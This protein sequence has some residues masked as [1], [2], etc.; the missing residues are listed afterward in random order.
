MTREEFER[1]F[2]SRTLAYLPGFRADPR[3]VIVTIGEAGHSGPGH[4]LV[5]SLANQLARAHRRLIFCGDL[6]RPLQFRDPFGAKTLREATIGQALAINP[7]IEMTESPEPD[8]R[9]AL[10]TIGIAAPAE[11]RVGCLGWCALFGEEVDVDPEDEALLGAALASSM[12][13][14]VAF[15]RQLG[16]G[17]AP[18]G[19]YSLWDYGRQSRRKARL[20]RPDRR[21][22]D[23][24]G[25]CGCGRVR[26]G[27]LAPCVRARIAPDGRRR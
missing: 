21:R 12:A 18:D 26:L 24:A 11:L 8:V 13:A 3:P 14:A 6:D 16:V 4:A 15:H 22:N 17:G 23:P 5:A 10:L 20:Q 2:Y 25:G 19:S 27:L 9:D 7:F 1:D